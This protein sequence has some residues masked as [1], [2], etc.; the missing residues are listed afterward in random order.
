MN[1]VVLAVSLVLILSLFRVNV[2]LSLCLGA[3]A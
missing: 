2:I 1:A 3:L